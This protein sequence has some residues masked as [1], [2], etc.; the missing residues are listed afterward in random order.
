M[1]AKVTRFGCLGKLFD[2]GFPQPHRM[3]GLCEWPFLP[4]NF[5]GN[6]SIHKNIHTIFVV[7]E[8]C[9]GQYFSILIKL[10]KNKFKILNF[11]I[12]YLLAN[13][14]QWWHFFLNS[15]NCSV[16]ELQTVCQDALPKK[17]KNN[18][19]KKKGGGEGQL[20]KRKGNITLRH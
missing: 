13:Y 19:N 3:S 18:N 7:L 11:R 4:H 10:L 6:K 20:Q 14:D 16:P 17:K 5:K 12:A 8:N 9:Q 2:V 15:P 1:V